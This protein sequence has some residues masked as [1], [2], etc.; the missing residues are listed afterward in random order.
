M[1]VRLALGSELTAVGLRMKQSYVP[2]TVAIMYFLVPTSIPFW[3]D[4]RTPGKA[5]RHIRFRV[6]SQRIW[7]QQ[8][9]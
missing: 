9:I 3:A 6:Y 2:A 4:C 1:F 7:R 8:T 5:I